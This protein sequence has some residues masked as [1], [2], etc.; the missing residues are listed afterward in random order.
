[1]SETS[2]GRRKKRKTLKNKEFKPFWNEKAT[3]L[4]QQWGLDVKNPLAAGIQ[5]EKIESNSWF[6]I[7]KHRQAPIM[8]NSLELPP[9][10]NSEEELTR[11]R[12]I[13]LYP[14]TS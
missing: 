2:Q 9:K 1:M 12:H 11:A 10:V 7:V 6:S 13:R 14:T 8:S 3:R 5:G 4:S